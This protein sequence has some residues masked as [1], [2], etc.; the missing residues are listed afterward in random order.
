[1]NNIE[2]NNNIIFNKL[3]SQKRHYPLETDFKLLAE[4]KKKTSVGTRD[5]KKRLAGGK[6]ILMSYTLNLCHSRAGFFPHMNS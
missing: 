1:M 4:K 6:S 3:G 2:Y 5:I